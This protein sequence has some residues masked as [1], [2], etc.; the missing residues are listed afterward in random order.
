MFSPTAGLQLGSCRR[1]CPVIATLCVLRVSTGK[2][3]S[4]DHF[5]S[6]VTLLCEKSELEIVIILKWPMSLP[7]NPPADIEA[8]LPEQDDNN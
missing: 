6:G 3:A 2:T 1:W 5:P 8:F 7:S 4:Q